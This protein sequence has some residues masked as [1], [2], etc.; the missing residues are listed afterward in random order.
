MEVANCLFLSGEVPRFRLAQWQGSS[1]ISGMVTG[2]LRWSSGRWRDLR[3]WPQMLVEGLPGRALRLARAVGGLTV[4]R[5]NDEPRP[6]HQL[7][8]LADRLHR[9]LISLFDL[10]GGPEAAQLVMH[11]GM[12][13]SPLS[14]PEVAAIAS[15]LGPGA[16]AYQEVQVAQGGILSL[17][18]RLNGER[19]FATWHTIHLPEGKRGDLSLLVHEA[20]H[21]FQYEQL[22]S[23]YIGEALYAQR[24]LGRKCYDYGGT[25]GL[26]G[27][28]AYCG[29]NREA[30]AQI[31]QD[32]YRRQKAGKEVNA[33]LPYV[34][35]LRRAAF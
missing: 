26:E 28:R 6:A 7:P 29:F 2:M 14:P 4:E 25:A 21:I 19:A 1:M 31:A 18:F 12:E 24:R 11:L 15:V 9:V 30:Q 22:G 16:I 34:A 33:Y 5:V 23:A 8:L 27:E 10:M 35:A 32:F 3:R 17:V 20:T 13:T